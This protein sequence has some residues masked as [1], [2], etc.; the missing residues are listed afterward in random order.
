MS[1]GRKKRSKRVELKESILS[2]AN[3]WRLPRP[4][5]RGR[6]SQ[7]LPGEE[8]AQEETVPL[9]TGRRTRER[10]ERQ[11]AASLARSRRPLGRRLATAPL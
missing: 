2:I 8:R 5:G 11:F 7:S 1:F 4:R 10:Q 3:Y 6:R 9:G